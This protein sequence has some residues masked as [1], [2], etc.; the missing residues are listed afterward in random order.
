MNDLCI[1]VADGARARLFVVEADAASRKGARLVEQAALAQ[2]D[3]RTLGTSVT[4]RPRTETNTNRQA[5]PVHP[6]G[7]QRER[8]RLDIERRFASSITETAAGLVDDWTKGTV[9]LIAE[10]RMLGLLRETVRSVLKP[11]IAVK[12]L[13]RDFTSLTIAELYDRLV[14]NG[15]IR[16][17]SGRNGSR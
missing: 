10:P 2:P 1:V 16:A 7:A 15:V 13:A 11:G 14:R 4:G 3:L 12:E 5:G 17:V 9:V 8:H 6:M